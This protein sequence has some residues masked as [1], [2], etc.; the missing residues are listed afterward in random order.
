MPFRC[1]AKIVIPFNWNSET[2]QAMYASVSSDRMAVIFSDDR[3][4]FDSVY[5]REDR[6]QGPVLD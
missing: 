3:Q 2:G 4:Y 6:L 5:S 1:P